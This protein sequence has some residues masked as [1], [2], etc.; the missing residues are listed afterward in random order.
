MSHHRHALWPHGASMTFVTPLAGAPGQEAGEGTFHH[1]TA[2]ATGTGPLPVVRSPLPGEARLVEEV[3]DLLS[4][5]MWGNGL[6]A[7]GAAHGEHAARMERRAPCRVLAAQ[8][9]R[10]RVAPELGRYRDTLDSAWDL[11]EEGQHLAGIAGIPRRHSV[12]TEKA[13]RRGRR[14]PRLATK[15]RGAMALACEDG[16]AGAL[17]GIDEFPVTALVAV[18]EACGLRAE[19]R[20]AAQRPVERLGDPA[21]A[22]RAAPVRSWALPAPGA[23]VPCGAPMSPR[24]ALAL[25]MG[26]H[27]IA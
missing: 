17:V 13:R 24:R 19:G 11:V 15:L 14:D 4:P 18:A 8:G 12:G 10:D 6:D 1:R 20:L 21:G 26:G 27:S 5:G 23:S 25:G 22:G 2:R 16:S 3:A 9:T 7:L